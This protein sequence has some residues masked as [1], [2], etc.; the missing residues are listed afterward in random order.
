MYEQSEKVGDSICGSIKDCGSK[1]IK[2]RYL[3]KIREKNVAKHDQ[4]PSSNMQTRVFP[5]LSHQ[6]KSAIIL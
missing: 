4:T 2:F 6:C 3:D 1:L 5:V